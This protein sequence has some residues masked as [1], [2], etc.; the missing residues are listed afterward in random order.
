MA[1]REGQ[2]EVFVIGNRGEI[3]VNP[4]LAMMKE[5]DIRG[6]ALWNVTPEQ[7]K[8][9]M[10]D[11]MAGVAEGALDG[12]AGWGEVVHPDDLPG[13]RQAIDAQLNLKP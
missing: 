1:L 6:I 7:V 4:R 10:Q 8:P 3:T 12:K 5:L 11:I 2:S 13:L 9:M